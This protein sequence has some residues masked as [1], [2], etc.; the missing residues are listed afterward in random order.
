MSREA[1]DDH[2]GAGVGAAVRLGLR[3]LGIG[4]FAA[5]VS[6]AMVVVV[7]MVIVVVADVVGSGRSSSS[8]SES[9]RVVSAWP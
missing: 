1:G 4:V 9:F 8:S 7:V 3:P 2:S 6:T 5:W